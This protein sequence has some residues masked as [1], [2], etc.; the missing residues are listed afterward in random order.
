MPIKTFQTLLDPLHIDFTA[1]NQTKVSN[2]VTQNLSNV[3]GYITGIIRVNA[4]ENVI[5]Q[6]Q[7]VDIL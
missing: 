5:N 2:T 6:G 1:T 4:S 3:M 7:T